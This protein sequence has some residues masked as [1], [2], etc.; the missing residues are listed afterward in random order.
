MDRGKP[1]PPASQAFAGI[2]RSRQSLT[3]NLHALPANIL[4]VILLPMHPHPTQ[5]FL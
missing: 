1:E 2:G 3:Q 5:A 4:A